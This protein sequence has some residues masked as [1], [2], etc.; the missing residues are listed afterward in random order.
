MGALL[1]T[2]SNGLHTR[3]SRLWVPYSSHKAMYYTLVLLGF[4]CP[5]LHT[6]QWASRLWVPYSSHRAMDYTLGRTCSVMLSSKVFT[7]Q[8][9]TSHTSFIIIQALNRT[10]HTAVR[11]GFFTLSL[12][13]CRY[14][15]RC[16][17]GSAI[18]IMG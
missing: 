18:I 10:K 17:T 5:T 14:P 9:I 11:F 7:I 15:S 2:Q 12:R 3:A 8:V 6:K 16:I 4:G 1:F 13:I